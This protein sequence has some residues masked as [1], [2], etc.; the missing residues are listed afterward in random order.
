MVSK[1]GLKLIDKILTDIDRN[2]IVT[3]TIVDRFTKPTSVCY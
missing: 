3:N 1:E 2:G